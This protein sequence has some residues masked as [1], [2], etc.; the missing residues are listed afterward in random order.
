MRYLKEYRRGTYITLLT[1]SRLNTHLADIDKQ[2]QERMERPIEQM[3]QA[4]GK[5]HRA[6]E[7]GAWDH[8]QLKTEIAL[9][10]MQRMNNI[11]M[12]AKEIVEKAVTA[13]LYNNITERRKLKCKLR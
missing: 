4:H 13:F 5:A 3:K 11:R 6:D 8:E 9:E 12:C 7:T 1:S 2:A 10:W